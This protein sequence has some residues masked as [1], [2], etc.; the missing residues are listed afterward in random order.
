MLTTNQIATAF[1]CTP[2]QLKAQYTANANQMRSMLQRVIT[3]GR[4]VNGYS[5]DD[6]AARIAKFESLAA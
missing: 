2:A 4:R 6:L 3:T 5:A 1:N